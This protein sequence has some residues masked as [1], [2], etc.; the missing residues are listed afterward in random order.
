MKFRVT[1]LDGSEVEVV[2]TASALRRFE[3][4]H[5]MSIVAAVTTGRSFWA[6][7]LAYYSLVQT[8][9]LEDNG[10]EE[11]LAGVQS[12]QYAATEDKVRQVASL[13]GI[14]VPEEDDA[15]PTGREKKSPSRAA[16][17]KPRSAR[18]KR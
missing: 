10:L 7:E 2:R 13:I 3:Q 5:E 1:Y 16:S 18:A 4:E 15:V 11:W 8:T 12:I 9:D 6:D 17:S 14:Y